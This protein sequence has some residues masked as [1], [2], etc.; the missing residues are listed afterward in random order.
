MKQP[1]SSLSNVTFVMCKKIG[2]MNVIMVLN[3]G[4]S[5]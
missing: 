3:S 5:L 4:E 2:I 1:Q